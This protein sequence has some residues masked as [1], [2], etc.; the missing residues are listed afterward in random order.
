[1]RTKLW[2]WLIISVLCGMAWIIVSAHFNITG[3]FFYWTSYG[4]WLALW[5]VSLFRFLTSYAN[6]R[7]NN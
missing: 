4:A 1:M 6:K 3:G 5:A 7:R 2:I